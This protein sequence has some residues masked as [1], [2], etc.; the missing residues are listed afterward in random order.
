MRA[1]GEGV[2][3]ELQTR[4]PKVDV[5]DAFGILHPQ[6]FLAGGTFEDFEKKL[7]VLIRHF[8]ADKAMGG[9]VVE[10]LVDAAKLR[11]TSQWFYDHAKHT[12]K[13]RFPSKTPEEEQLGAGVGESDEED[14]D[15]ELIAAMEVTGEEAEDDGQAL[16]G[17]DSGSEGSGADSDDETGCKVEGGKAAS[18]LTLFWTALTANTAYTAVKVSAF[19]HL[20]EILFVVVG[21]SVED[22]RLFSAA[23][24]VLSKHRRRLDASLEKCVRMKVQSVFTLD[25]FPY[26]EAV[27]QWLAA[28][29]K[30]GRYLGKQGPA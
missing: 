15:D 1:V 7:D 5:L 30:R 12:A 28:A 19:A 6:F 9:K 11:E 4:F 14:S 17:D 23:S 20:A 3:E 27:Q 16:V 18:K 25:N 21:G 22:E 10:A 2:V 26:D 8:G 13:T 29:P 24:F